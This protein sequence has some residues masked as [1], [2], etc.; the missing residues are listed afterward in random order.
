[1]K[2]TIWLSYDL[3]VKGDFPGLYAWLDNHNAK[4]AGNSVAFLQYEYEGSDLLKALEEDLKQN[5]EFNPRDRVYVI[6]ITKS[7][8]KKK[9]VGKFI[10][11]N[12]KASPWEGYGQ[13]GGD[14]VDT[15]E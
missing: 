3:G 7:K 13:K 15:D 9:T 6:H 2:D 10:V 14:I 11:G 5:V 4:E 8:G 12:R 1:M